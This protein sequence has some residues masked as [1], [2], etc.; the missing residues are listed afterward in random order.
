MSDILPEDTVAP[1]TIENTTRLGIRKVTAGSTNAVEIINAALRVIDSLVATRASEGFSGLCTFEDLTANVGS[2]GRLKAT[3]ATVGTSSVQALTAASATIKA[4]KSTAATVTKLTSPEAVLDLATVKLVAAQ[5]I[6]SPKGTISSLTS[7][8]AKITDTLTS[9]MAVIRSLSGTSVTTTKLK[10]ASIDTNSVKTSSMSASTGMF[11]EITVQKI[12]L[13]Q[14]FIGISSVST[15][16]ID[17]ATI[18]VDNTA[19]SSYD[20]Y[21]TAEFN[22]HLV[23]YVLEVADILPIK[24]K[25]LLNL[26]TGVAITSY[27]I[28]SSGAWDAQP[29]GFSV[30]VGF[31]VHGGLPQFNVVYDVDTKRVTLKRLNSLYIESVEFRMQCTLIRFNDV[32]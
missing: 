15:L 32:E 25:G 20:A 14:S 6:S 19:D 17:S 30:G 31:P 24:V 23:E 21:A 16:I 8:S 12:N 27:D 26:K 5:D 10:A 13:N 3:T 29:S 4:L 28:Q 18:A 11:D 22:P 7:T 1:G 9:D 2:I